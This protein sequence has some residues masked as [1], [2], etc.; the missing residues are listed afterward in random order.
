MEYV[1]M[2]EGLEFSRVVLG[3]WRLLDWNLSTDE[4]IRYLEECLDLGSRRWITQIFTGTTRS[5][6]NSGKP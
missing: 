2:A 5:K 1:T 3:F 4:L 6:R